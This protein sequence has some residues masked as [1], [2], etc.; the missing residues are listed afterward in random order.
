MRIAIVTTSFPRNPGDAAGHFVA[1]EAVELAASDEARVHVLAAGGEREQLER[2]GKL[3]VHWLGGGSSFDCPGVAVQLRTR[4]WQAPPL[5]L[6]YGFRLRRQLARLAP[7]RII[8]HWL[9]PNAWPLALGLAPELEVVAHGADVR[10]LLAL[11][12]LLRCRVIDDLVDHVSQVRFAG[13]ELREQL[14]ASLDDAVARRLA[15]RSKVA[16]PIIHLDQDLLESPVDPAAVRAALGL[17]PRQ[18]AVAVVGR[19]IRSKRVDLALR[20]VAALPATAQVVVVGEGPERAAL[21]QLAADLGVRATF[22]GQLTRPQALRLIA[23]SDVLMHPSAQ[24]AAPSAVREA[25]ALGVPVVACDAGDVRY[26]ARS[27]PGIGVHAAEP[28][29]LAL[30]LA[31]LLAQP[32]RAASLLPTQ[33]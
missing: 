1:A 5:L 11:P 27:D 30:A 2:R 17:A 32:G 3:R 29:A 23:A 25:R 22:T 6:R 33:R 10:L 8:A 13:A 9:V 14:L 31:P 7:E 28:T 26:W 20:A 19:L 12:R 16:R 4:P 15:A 24:E 18:S 21:E